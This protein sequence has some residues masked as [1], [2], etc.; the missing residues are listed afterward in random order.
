MT[1]DSD[2]Q[3]VAKKNFCEGH[4]IH[5]QIKPRLRS[6]A[7]LDSVYLFFSLQLLPVRENGEGEQDRGAAAGPIFNDNGCGQE[8]A[9]G[10]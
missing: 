2:V 7:A 10:Q 8:G 5:V 1:A 3:Y 6:V 4:I 9:P